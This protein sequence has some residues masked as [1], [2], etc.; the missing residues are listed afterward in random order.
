MITLKDL[1]EEYTYNPAGPEWGIVG[2]TLAEYLGMEV[3][4]I[5]F[6][7]NAEG[8]WEQKIGKALLISLTDYDPLTETSLLSWKEVDYAV[9]EKDWKRKETRVVGPGFSFGNPEDVGEMTR[10]LPYSLHVR[11]V[12]TETLNE[13]LKFAFLN[14]SH[15]AV[16]LEDLQVLANGKDRK[17][18]L[19]EVHNLRLVVMPEGEDRVATYRVGDIHVQHQIKSTY[20]ITLSDTR[21]KGEVL[22]YYDSS[23]PDKGLVWKEKGQVVATARIFALKDIFNLQ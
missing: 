1:K 22:F 12:E 2:G 6:K 17:R 15:R 19:K 3:V 21:G 14:L 4:K 8:E 16:S 5:N 13:K 20:K 9:P 18:L 10:F 11:K 7:K 23:N